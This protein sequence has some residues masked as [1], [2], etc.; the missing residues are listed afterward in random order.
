MQAFKI[1]TVQ[2]LND[3]QKKTRVER[4]RMLKRRAVGFWHES[5]VFSD[6]KI[7][8]VE[9]V[10]NKENDRV[11]AVARSSTHSKDFQATRRQGAASLMVWAGIS[12]SGRTP[13]V[14]V[15]HG[16]KINPQIYCETILEGCLK[17]WAMGQYEANH[18]IFQQDSAPAHA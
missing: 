9:Q 3:A 1:K 10:V 13:L 2:E 15:V 16:V 18:W 7:S 14:F 5:V 17:P 8:T 12:A 6:E 11:W 4:C